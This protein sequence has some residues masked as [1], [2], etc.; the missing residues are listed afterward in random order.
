M[1]N[2]SESD[3]KR[4]CLVRS[5]NILIIFS[6]QSMMTLENDMAIEQSCTIKKTN[7]D[8]LTKVE[9]YKEELEWWDESISSSP[10][11]LMVLFPGTLGSPIPLIGREDKL[12]K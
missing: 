8:N 2:Q 11:L 7:F 3:P 1:P 4:Q 10:Y 9:T 6:K 5:F 12:M